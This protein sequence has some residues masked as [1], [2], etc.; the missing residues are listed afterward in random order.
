MTGKYEIELYNNRVHF[1]LEIKRNITIIQGDSATG[2][3]TLISLIA[4]YER[5]GVGSG[6]T[7][8]C[9]KPCSVLNAG[10]WKNYLQN[11]H[12]HVIFM[13]ENMPFIKS[14]EFAERVNKSDNYFVIIFRE[15]LPQL[16]YSVEEIY[17]IR[18]DRDSQKYVNPRRVFNA[19]YQIYN[20]EYP[21]KIKP[22]VVITEDSNAGYEFFSQ[23][24]PCTCVSAGG[25]TLV[26]SKIA[27]MEDDR[28][29]I[30]AI[31]DGAAFGADMQR[32]MREIK[33][34]KGKCLLYAPE[35]FEYLILRSGVVEVPDKYLD[36]PYNYAD[37]A[38][39]AS[40]ERYFTDQ[41]SEATRNTI[42]QYTKS[43]LNV[44]YLT[45][46]NINRI[47]KLL[48]GVLEWN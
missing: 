28:E 8:K 33:L 42:Y 5:L 4:D 43:K 20:L 36:E 24:L 25:K 35:S 6:I 13:D 23:V 16:A 11:V 22:T 21:Q 47:M 34:K 45:A 18:E 41:L 17:G 2:K 37:S 40:W 38:R 3:S 1:F 31:V 30:I 46:G 32:A 12:D 14:R 19:L 39:Y 7:L 9:E 10:D 27:E 44:I 15:S 29:T 26:H 48:P